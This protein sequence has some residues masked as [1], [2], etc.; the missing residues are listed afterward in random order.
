MYGLT[1]ADPG[2]AAQVVITVKMKIIKPRQ[3]RSRSEGLSTTAA[4]K[5]P[6]LMRDRAPLVARRRRDD[7]CVCAQQPSDSPGRSGTT[8]GFSLRDWG[9][10][11]LTVEAPRHPLEHVGADDVAVDQHRQRDRGWPG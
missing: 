9:V 6:S 2:A 10:H 4:S 3:R 1:G 5:P 11:R 8:T 7:D